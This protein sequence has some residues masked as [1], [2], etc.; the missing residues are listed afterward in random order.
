MEVLEK[1]L[2]EVSRGEMD[3]TVRWMVENTPYRLAGSED[4]RRASEY[5][6]QRMREYGLEVENEEFYTYN[7]DPQYSK[8]EVLS[9]EPMVIESLPCAHI[10][11]TDPRGEEFD[12]VYVGTGSYEAYEGLDVRGKMVLVEV[13][14]AP[15]VPEKGRIACEM[16][17]AG[18]IC[19]NWGND[20]EVICHRGLKAV[21]GNPTEE[22]FPDIPD[23]IGVGITR[24][25]G[26]RLKELCLSGAPVRLR[27]TAVATRTWSKVHQP[28]GILRGNGTS[29]EFLLVCSHLDA[30]KPGVT[31]NA[32]GNSTALEICRIFSKYRDKLDRDVYFVFWNGHEIA[33]AAGSTWFVD[34][35]WD[36]LT[37]K[38]VC[39]MH[40]DSTG[41]SQTKIFEIKASDELLGFSEEN[42][43]EL[44]GG[45]IRAMALK[46]IGD[47]S[48]M[49]IGVP[50]VTQR[51]SFTQEDM[52]RAHGA[53]LGWW[54]HTKEDGIDKCDLAILET[55]T[56]VTLALLFK[57]ASAKWLPYDFTGK[58][59]AIEARV[60]KIEEICGEKLDLL[61][62]Q[63]NLR[64]AR[65]HILDIQSRRAGCSADKAGYYNRFMKNVCHLLTDVFQTYAG[66]YEQDSYGYT[67][68]S[69]PIPLF[70]DAERL[71]GLPEDSMEYGMVL[72][73]LIKN[74]NRISDALYQICELARLTELVL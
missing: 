34:K 52:D 39:Y 45:E 42:V 54:N 15:P 74:R 38:C 5:V 12:L 71:N 53:T 30:W 8:V 57:L 58:F 13:S 73:Q 2:S 11:S 35:Y 41:V 1:M 10:K 28:K 66:K 21:W 33:E 20:E 36:L 29:D 51:M 22:T 37:K 46:K 65:E 61:A 44:I 55:D 50:S 70:A 9:P 59:R 19:M 26:L 18:M 62:L 24:L 17:A 64:E 43:T 60:D 7:S 25:S 47:Q 63:A 68:L 32:T 6:C 3:K 48:F 56:R 31:C 72:T 69:S 49:G 23:I 14:Y 4:E 27:I 40:I 16:G 67:K